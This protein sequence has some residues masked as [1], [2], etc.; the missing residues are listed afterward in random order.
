M[1][2]LEDRSAQIIKLLPTGFAFIALTIVVTVMPPSLFDV[3]RIAFWTFHPI[4]PAQFVHNIIAFRIID[5]LLYVHHPAI[6]P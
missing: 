3:R 1:M 4:Q 2:S 6:L 5:Q